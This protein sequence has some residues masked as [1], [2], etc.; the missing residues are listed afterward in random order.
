MNPNTEYCFVLESNSNAFLTWVGQMGDFDVLTKEP[1]DK[2]PYAGVLFKSQNSSTWTPEQ[3]Q[4]LKFKINRAKF[5]STGTLV[6]ENKAIPSKKL[7]TNPIEVFSGDKDRVK[8]HHQSH[9]MY[10]DKSN[11]TISGVEGDKTNSILS[12]SVAMQGTAAGVVN[13]G[14]PYTGKTGSASGNGAGHTFDITL[15][16]VNAISNITINNPGYNFAVNETITIL[17]NQVG[18]SNTNTFATLTVTAIDDSLGGIPISKI[19]KTHDVDTNYANGTDPSFTSDMDSYEFNVDLGNSSGSKH[20]GTTESTRAGGSSVLATENMYFDVIHTLVPNIVYPK[21][22][23]SASMFK[24]STGGVNNTNTPASYSK[25]NV[26]ET[27]VLNDKNFVTTSGIVASQVNETGEM[28]GEKSFKLELAM[29]STSDFVSPVVDVASIGANTIMN[30]INSVSV[31]SDIASDR[32]AD[33]ID[34]TEPEGDNNAAIYCTRLVQLENPASQLKVIFDG[35][36]PSGSAEGEIKTYYKL[37]SAD[38]TL[39]VEELGW[40]EFATTNVPDADSSK[41]RS[42]EYDATNLE[43]FVGFAIKIVIKSKNTTMPCAI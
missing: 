16:A 1:I 32:A 25:S 6:L 36:K 18:G 3:M 26:A 43:E 39:P 5:S 12:V 17:N 2:Q 14:T 11:F 4:D 29:T 15:S 13:S 21:T 31:L 23:I 38:S 40:T 33:L 28:G 35:F 34:G 27:K 19:N 37:L 9:G 10:S 41:F 42:Y 22:G 30:R 8:V 20:K 7:K 24:T